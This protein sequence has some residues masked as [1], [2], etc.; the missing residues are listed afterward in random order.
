MTNLEKFFHGDLAKL[1][2]SDLE[3]RLDLQAKLHGVAPAESAVQPDLGGLGPPGRTEKPKPAL[4]NLG[5]EHLKLTRRIS[6]AD[7]NRRSELIRGRQPELYS[8]VFAGYRP[9]PAYL[10]G[11]VPPEGALSEKVSVGG[12]TWRQALQP[13][14]QTDYLP[15]LANVARQ[16]CRLDKQSGSQ[17]GS[18]LV[19][20]DGTVLTN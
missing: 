5:V 2:L 3:E 12:I 9:A 1:A 16:C 14:T 18:G 13:D 10:A 20:E 6:D 4:A 7:P 8:I 17:A 15:I 19:L 11:H